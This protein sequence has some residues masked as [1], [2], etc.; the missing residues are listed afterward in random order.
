MTAKPKNWSQVLAAQ[1]SKLV[2]LV[3]VSAIV[4]VLDQ[5]TKH[6][7]YTHFKWGESRP[8][9]DGLFSLTYVRNMGA[10]FGFLH[11]APPWFRDPFFI[12]IPILALFMILFLLAASPAKSKLAPLGLS[13]VFGG[14]IGNLIDRL[15]FGYVVDFLDFYWKTSHWPAFNVADSCIVVGVGILFILSFATGNQTSASTP[16]KA[17]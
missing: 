9:I 2:V 1:K 10:A 16:K 8:V 6:L 7:V 12:I 5:W 13:L 14:A 11:N 15:R 17:A 4:L 3:V